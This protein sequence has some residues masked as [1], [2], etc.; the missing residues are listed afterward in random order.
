MVG[1]ESQGVA[2]VS[3]RRGELAARRRTVGHT[4]ESLA[5]A[6]GVDRATTARWERG[7]SQPQPWVRRGLAAVLTL[8]LDELDH[9]LH[10][11]SAPIDAP[12]PADS[13]QGHQLAGARVTIAICGS[14]A[15]DTEPQIIDATVGAL[16]R[17]VMIS[18]CK[19]N[20]GPVG[21]GIEVMTYIADHYR[22]PDF[23]AAMGLFGRQNV[24]RNADYVIVVGGAT[25]TAEE[26][27]LAVYSGTTIIPLPASG[28]T[29]RRIYERALSNPRL[30]RCLPERHFDTLATCTDA[31]QFVE[32]VKNALEDRQGRT[33]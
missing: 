11:A 13:E 4:Q 8:S 17:F 2:Q 20:H 16:A 32:I 25:G 19:V 24:V 22:P 14:R 6:L 29:A 10:A 7:E 3:R 21:V 31:D 27:D 15:G 28:G 23:T 33:P 1:H 5:E 12:V 18:R 9:L 26:I 30:R